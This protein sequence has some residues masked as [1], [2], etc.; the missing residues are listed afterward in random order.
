M[1]GYQNIYST[2]SGV[3]EV[4]VFRQS[5]VQSRV[6]TRVQNRQSREPRRQSRDP[7]H[8]SHALGDDH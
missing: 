2:D 4:R 5:N 8:Q 3:R 6:Q 7:R 1:K